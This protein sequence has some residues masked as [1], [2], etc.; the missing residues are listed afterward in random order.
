MGYDFLF[1]ILHKRRRIRESFPFPN[2]DSSSRNKAS[3]YSDASSAT[4]LFP[5]HSYSYC[6]YLHIWV[7]NRNYSLFTHC[8]YRKIRFRKNYHQPANLIFKKKNHQ[9][10]VSK[11]DEASLVFRKYHR[12]FLPASLIAYT[13]MNIQC[14]RKLS[15]KNKII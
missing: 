8:W 13:K 11:N 9:W 10:L 6:S 15:K 2:L 5:I 7:L 1:S 14:R 12:P 4:P 3:D